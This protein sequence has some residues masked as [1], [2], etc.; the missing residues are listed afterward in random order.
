MMQNYWSL[1]LRATPYVKFP[2]YSLN[3]R[4]DVAMRDRGHT[5]VTHRQEYLGRG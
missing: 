2:K 5:S 1:A 4:T 3:S